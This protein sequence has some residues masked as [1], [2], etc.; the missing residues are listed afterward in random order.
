MRIFAFAVLMVFLVLAA[1]YESWGLPLA[2]ILVVPMCLLSAVVGVNFAAMDINV[3]TQ[4]GFVVLVGLAS[5]NAILI[6]EFA[7]SRREVGAPVREATLEACRLRLRPII[8]TSL[9][10]ILGAVPL[11]TSQGA[12]AEMRQALGVAVFGGMIGVTMF[13]LFLTPIF[14]YFVDSATHNRFFSLPGV[15]LIGDILLG[16]LLVGPRGY[17][18]RGLSKAKQGLKTI[19]GIPA[20]QRMTSRLTIRNW[21]A[22]NGEPPNPVNGN[23]I[24]LKP[25]EPVRSDDDP[26]QT[27]K[28]E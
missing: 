7:K 16:M 19:R 18:V 25:T 14:F 10:F 21:K 17:L 9:A 24:T 12:G 13:G 6:V 11:V 26:G 22:P 15:Q 28:G 5:K 23:G 8:M 3:F 27:R 1:Q 4:V 20:V 2:V